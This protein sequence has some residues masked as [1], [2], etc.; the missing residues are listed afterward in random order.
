MIE[1]QH[2]VAPRKCTPAERYVTAVNEYIAC[3]PDFLYNPDPPEPRAGHK[4]M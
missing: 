3:G 1:F 4:I 2:V